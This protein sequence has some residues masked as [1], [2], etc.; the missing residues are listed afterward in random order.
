VHDMKAYVGVE[1]WLHS[2][3][4]PELDVGVWMAKNHGICT[5]GEGL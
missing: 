3:K 2:L 5:P 4:V 1:E